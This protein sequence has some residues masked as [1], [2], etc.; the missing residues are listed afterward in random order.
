MVTLKQVIQLLDLPDDEI[1]AFCIKAEETFA[2]D[3]SVR[4]IKKYLDM[5]AIMIRK[6]GLFHYR[7]SSDVSLEFI[8]DRSTQDLIKDTCRKKDILY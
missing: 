2:P 5:Q 1:I 6:V 8:V 4:Q 3:M 7:Y